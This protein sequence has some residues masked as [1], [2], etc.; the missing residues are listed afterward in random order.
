MQKI[1][2]EANSLDKRCY[3][4]FDL[5]ED[6]LMENASIS[7]MNYIDQNFQYQDKII[8]VCGAGNNGADGIVLARLLHSKYNVSLYLPHGVKSI[9]AQKQLKR[10]QKLKVKVDTKLTKANVIIDCLFGS[11]LNRDLDEKSISIIKKMNTIDAFKISCDIP[12]GINHLGQVTTQAFYANITITM[13][14]LKKS[15]FTDI[16]KEYTGLIKVSNLGIQRKLY[17]TKTNTFL[18]DKGDLKL[19][20]R[21]NKISN[22][23]TFGHLS[24]V[25]GE[26]IGAGL[27]CADAGFSFGCG[28]ITVVTKELKKIPN[29]IM[30]NN[31]TP[32]NTSALCIGMGLGVKYDKKLL[33]S[34]LPKVIDAD[35]FYD[36]NIIKILKQK[37]IVF[38]SS[39][40]RILFL[41][42]DYKSC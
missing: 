30:Q 26:K 19:P 34:S 23:G 33:S 13:G 21:N 2:D 17:E 18:L 24:V 37:N 38:N 12:S 35:L 27:L 22:K 41:I 11:G 25:L 28:L 20:L 40:K 42:K 6:I 31:T 29:Y 39:S 16:S 8:I 36:K 10:A 1:F 9:M 14:A 7:M 4:K 5:T 3:E 32:L 15:L